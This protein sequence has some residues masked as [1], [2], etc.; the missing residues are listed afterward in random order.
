MALTPSRYDAI[1]IGAGHNG[2]VT[3]CYLARA[4][5]SVLVLET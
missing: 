3:A 1:V 4:G 2:L 5:L